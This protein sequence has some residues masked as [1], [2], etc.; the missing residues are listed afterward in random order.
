MHKIKINIFLLISFCLL[1]IQEN[2]AN[3]KV[4]S[5][6]TSDKVADDTIKKNDAESLG[7]IE[8]M[9]M[10]L[11][12]DMYAERENSQASLLREENYELVLKIAAD[13]FK[14]NIDP[15][16]K[17]RLMEIIKYL[18]QEKVFTKE[19]GFLGVALN[20]ELGELTSGD[21]KISGIVISQ[22]LPDYPAI[23]H[24][25][26]AGD[27]I[28]KIDKITCDENFQTPQLIDYIALKKPGDIVNLIL[29]SEGKK[30]KKSIQLAA[31][32]EE[33]IKKTLPDRKARFLEVWLNENIK[34]R[35]KN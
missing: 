26:K 6:D 14:R 10:G 30:I 27:W 29:L 17:I 1:G 34:L 5:K 20:Q 12:S 4:V 3:E 15:E 16:I 32:S 35:T 25:I 2:F 22:S 8:A 9:M 19:Q 31:K 18:V 21:I 23:K 7:K 28:I 13:K 11:G 33:S 24:G